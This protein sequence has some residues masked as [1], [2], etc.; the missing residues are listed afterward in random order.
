MK[1]K[2]DKVNHIITLGV[3]LSLMVGMICGII[4]GMT[5]QQMIFTAAAVEIAEGF[6]GAEINVEIDLN[7][8]QIIEGYKEVIETIIVP[9][10]IEE[11]K[12]D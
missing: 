7:E 11:V 1:T 12:N 5:I 10:L 4:I 8:T 9:A 2:Q 3:I 6:D